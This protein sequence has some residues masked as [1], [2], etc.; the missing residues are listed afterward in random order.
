VPTRATLAFLAAVLSGATVPHPASGEAVPGLIFEA[1]AGLDPAVRRLERIDPARLQA[2]VRMVGLDSPGGP[3]RIVLAREDSDLA[4]GTPSWVPAFAAGEVI[5]IL[6]GRTL[7]YPHE[8]LEEVLQHEVAHVLV[9]RAAGHRPVPRWFHEGVALLAERAWNLGERTRFAHELA[10]GTEVSPGELDALFRGHVDSVERAY[11]L[12]GAFVRDLIRTY[13]PDLPARVLGAMRA[14]RE[15]DAAFLA[16]TGVTVDDA[17]RAFWR[18]HRLWLV[19]LPWLTSPE[20]VYTLMTALA[21]LA[22]WRVRA[23][24]AARRLAEEPDDPGSA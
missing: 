14:G 15:F 3:I 5:V 19:W 18:R 11:S 17:S 16:T 13:G 6:P 7:S 4:R 12:S 24:R 23:R 9:A 21:I 22:I 10:A 20:A 1:P 8:T 2:V